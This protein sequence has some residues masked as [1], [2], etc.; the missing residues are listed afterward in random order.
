[1]IDRAAIRFAGK[2]YEAP[3]PARHSD[4]LKSVIKAT[5]MFPAAAEFGFLTS[6]GRFVDRVKAATIA[7]ASGQLPSGPVG[8]LTTEHLW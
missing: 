7:L 4:L 5:R 8:K 2:L 6:D 3:R 1:M